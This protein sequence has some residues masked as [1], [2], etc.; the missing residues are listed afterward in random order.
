MA[1]SWGKTRPNCIISIVRLL[2]LLHYLGVQPVCG[3]YL[4]FRG[5]GATTVADDGQRPDENSNIPRDSSRTS[6]V[7]AAFV[8]RRCVADVF[9]LSEGDRGAKEEASQTLHS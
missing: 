5:Y 9:G 4:L 2:T 7:F 8:S 3:G 6:S 1:G